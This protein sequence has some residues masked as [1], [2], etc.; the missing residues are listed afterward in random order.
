MSRWHHSKMWS[1]AILPWFNLSSLLHIYMCVCVCVH[2]S[3]VMMGLMASPITRASQLF[4]RPFIQAEIK[5]N[6]KAPR[7][8]RLCG[9]FTGDRWIPLTKGQL[10]KMFPFDDVIMVCVCVCVHIWWSNLIT[11]VYMIQYITMLGHEQTLW[12]LWNYI[13]PH[14]IIFSGQ[15]VS[16]HIFTD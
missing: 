15:K 7:H 8:W 6:I 13:C 12:R 1:G 4:T 10:R 11:T 14:H 2:Y 3:D 16:R 9:E 5:E